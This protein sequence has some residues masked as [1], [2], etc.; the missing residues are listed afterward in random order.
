MNF[1]R[2]FVSSLRSSISATAASHTSVRLCGGMLVA[3]PTA[4]PVQPLISSCGIFAGS[5]IGS[6]VEPS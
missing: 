6:S 4:M 2:S 3:M 1:S 5:T